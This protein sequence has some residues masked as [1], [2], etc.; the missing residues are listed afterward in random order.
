MTFRELQESEHCQCH[1]PRHSRDWESN[2]RAAMGVAR[3][4]GEACTRE[5][6]QR[7]AVDDNERRFL[8]RVLDEAIYRI[9]NGEP[10]ILVAE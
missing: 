6:Y 3:K 7:K 1:A 8:M 5:A 4:C 9:E 2:V 10:R